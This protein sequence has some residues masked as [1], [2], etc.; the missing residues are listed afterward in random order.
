MMPSST[1]CLAS[2]TSSPPSDVYR[3]QYEK[4]NACSL[5]K[6]GALVHSTCSKLFI[7]GI[8]EVSIGEEVYRSIPKNIEN[9]NVR[10]GKFALYPS[11]PLEPASKTAASLGARPIQESV[12]SGRVSPNPEGAK[13]TSEQAHESSFIPLRSGSAWSKG[14]RERVITRWLATRIRQDSGRCRGLPN[15]A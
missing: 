8:Q 1:A 9:Q 11:T 14:F 13:H 2:T 7:L 10:L 3:R 4:A 12:L 15:G 5:Q 6:S